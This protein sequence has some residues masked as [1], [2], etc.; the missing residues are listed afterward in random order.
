MKGE[1][2]GLVQGGSVTWTRLET[3]GSHTAS[4]TVN[5]LDA[6]PSNNNTDDDDDDDAVEVEEED[7]CVL[8]SVAAAFVAVVSSPTP[9]SCFTPSPF[10]FS[11]PGAWSWSAD[12]S[13]HAAA[14]SNI[15]NT[16]GNNTL[17][18]SHSPSTAFNTHTMA[19]R[20]LSEDGLSCFQ[21]S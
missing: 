17:A 5:D 4:G 8:S 12:C 13:K 7:V 14:C 16:L 2:Y 1:M 9:S 6:N 15:H 11:I 18:G 20:P 21:P 10:T 19:E 3:K